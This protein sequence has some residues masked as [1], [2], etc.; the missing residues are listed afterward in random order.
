MNELNEALEALRKAQAL[1][2]GAVEL[3]GKMGTIVE[4]EIA[5]FIARA[6]VASAQAGARIRARMDLMVKET[7]D[8]VEGK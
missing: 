7:R 6:N 5:T 1:S 3:V 2:D 4:E 8:K